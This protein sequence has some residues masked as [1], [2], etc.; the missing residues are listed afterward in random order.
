MSAV[1][2][3]PVAQTANVTF[4]PD[5]V[6]VAQLRRAVEHCGFDCAGQSMPGCIC[7]P[8][9]EPHHETHDE[10]AAAVPTMPTVMATAA[11]P[12]PERT[13]TAVPTTTAT[14]ASANEM[15]RSPA[16]WKAYAR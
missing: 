4:D 8:L 7:D 12:E 10:A 9:A 5:Q 11:T 1:E 15:S 14:A 3:N 16:T 13:T 6:S 2:S